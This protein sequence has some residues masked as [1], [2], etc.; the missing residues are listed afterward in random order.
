MAEDQIRARSVIQ[1]LIDAEKIE[2]SDADYEA[3]VNSYAD[4]SEGWTPEKVAE[5]LAPDK[6]V[7]YG[8]AA[9]YEAVIRFIKENAVITKKE[10][11]EE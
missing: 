2:P 5:E 11:V 6:R 8:Q 1:A 9:L 7:K 3:A 10:K 4:R